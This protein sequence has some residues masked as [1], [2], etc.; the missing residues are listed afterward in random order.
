[1]KQLAQS[2]GLL[3]IESPVNSML[4]LRAQLKRFREPL[5]VEGMDGVARGLGLQPNS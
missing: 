2:L 3:G 5:L 1:M 4:M